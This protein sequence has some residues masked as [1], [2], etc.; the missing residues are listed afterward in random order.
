MT[1]QSANDGSSAFTGGEAAYYCV[2]VAM[3]VLFCFCTRSRIPDSRFVAAAAERRRQWEQSQDRKD[4]M[5][6]KDYR[7]ALVLKGLVFK[8]ITQEKD[9]FLTLGD[10]KNDG[11]DDEHNCQDERSAGGNISVD[12]MDEETSTCAICLEQFRVHDI[13]GLSR[14]LFEEPSEGATVCNHVFHKDCIVGRF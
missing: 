8:Q 9:G 4:R 1:E 13:V 11:D 7:A 14:T 6:D 3:L 10:C 12:S 2:A 5:N